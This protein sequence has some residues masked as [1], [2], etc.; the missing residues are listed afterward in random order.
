M[1]HIL[2][3][4]LQRAVDWI[5]QRYPDDED[6]NLVIVHGYDTIE[7]EDGQEV[8]AEIAV[9][10]AKTKTIYMVDSRTIQRNFGLSEEA[11]RAE[12]IRLLLREYWH[13]RRANEYLPVNEREAED[14]AR[15]M[16]KEYKKERK[17]TN[18]N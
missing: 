16:Y 7:F 5:N 12:I 17:S 2:P 6:V 9:H 14:F 13:H 11:A 8:K 15:V 10:D 4:W 1:I 18:E 3:E